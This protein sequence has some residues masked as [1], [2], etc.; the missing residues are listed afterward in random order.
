[1][2]QH[3][4]HIRENWYTG[5]KKKKERENEKGEQDRAATV[6]LASVGSQLACGS[7]GGR[8]TQSTRCHCWTLPRQRER[9]LVLSRRY[10]RDKSLPSEGFTLEGDDFWCDISEKLKWFSII[11]NIHRGYNFFVRL[12][13]HWPTTVAAVLHKLLQHMLS[14]WTA[15]TLEYCVLFRGQLNL[16]CFMSLYSCLLIAFFVSVY[17]DSKD[18]KTWGERRFNKGGD[19]AVLW[20]ARST[21]IPQKTFFYIITSHMIRL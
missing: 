16:F 14:T 3:V 1:M 2:W 19:V 11:E 9:R 17:W 4:S 15:I 6:V 18:K 5:S 20:C 7:A 13:H 8:R 12:W 21:R 10:Q